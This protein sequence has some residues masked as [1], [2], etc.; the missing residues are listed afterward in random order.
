MIYTDFSKAFDSA[1]HVRLLSKL[2]KYGIQGNILG[3]IKSFLSGR[4]H[5]VGVEGSVSNWTSVTSGIPQGFI[6]W[7][8]VI[9]H[10]MILKHTA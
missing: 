6:A 10:M 4:R 2:E 7:T 3:W 5:R 8:S 1:P 9:C